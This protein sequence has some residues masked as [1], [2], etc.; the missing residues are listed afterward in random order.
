MRHRTFLNATTFAAAAILLGCASGGAPNIAGGPGAVQSGSAGG[1]RPYIFGRCPL[2]AGSVGYP[3]TVSV[4]PVSAATRIDRA[5]LEEWASAAAL[6]WPVP[7]HRRTELPE[8]RNVAQRVLPDAPRWADD[9]LPSARHRAE[10][11]VTVHRGGA[12]AFS[13]VR[14]SGD[15]F[16]DRTLPGIVDDPLPAS[17]TLPTLPPGAP[18]SVRLVVRFGIEPAA[19]DSASIGVARFA[20]Q[21]RAVRVVPGTLSVLG[22]PS[23]RA[24]VAFVVETDGLVSPASITVLSGSRQTIGDAVREGLL[25][26]KFMPAEGDCEKIRLT[27]I[28]QFGR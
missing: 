17:P 20:R 4:A 24:V 15:G 14:G 11:Q 6:R 8:Y 10:A 3:I 2:P 5:W 9:W 26:A 13:I 1:E 25:D 22:A 7:S 16:F 21:Q 18:D 23:D 19:G 12:A 28:Q 27:V